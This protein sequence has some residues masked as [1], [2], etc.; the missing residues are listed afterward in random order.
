MDQSIKE[1]IKS[2]SSYA[3]KVAA[4]KSKDLHLD[5]DEKTRLLEE[6]HHVNNA[7]ADMLSM[8]ITAGLK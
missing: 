7:H 2:I 8:K 1:Y 3:D 4:I 6:L 5:Y